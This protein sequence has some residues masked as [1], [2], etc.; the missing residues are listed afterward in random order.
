MKVQHMDPNEW[1]VGKKQSQK[2]SVELGNRGYVRP[3]A[4]VWV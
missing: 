4:S 3:C 2:G 1:E